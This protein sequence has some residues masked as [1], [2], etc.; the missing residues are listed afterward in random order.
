MF[1]LVLP[2]VFYTGIGIT[3]LLTFKLAKKGINSV[4]KY[5]IQCS[6]YSSSLWILLIF[7]FLNALV[8]DYTPGSVCA[9]QLFNDQYNAKL[10]FFKSFNNGSE[11]R[12]S[13][14][15]INDYSHNPYSVKNHN[16]HCGKI[17]EEKRLFECY[18]ELENVT[19]EALSNQTVMH[20]QYYLEFERYID[21]ITPG[22]SNYVENI[23]S[24]IWFQTND[25][26]TDLYLD[27]GR[28]TAAAL[29]QVI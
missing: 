20:E 18:E 5:L 10:A 3:N 22:A 16:T 8:I 25:C 2:I 13:Y 28:Q 9:G 4:I 11:I 23:F 7:K 19:K 26:D 27:L 6:S 14:K 29:F 17:K 15:L 1:R 21:A 12:N 24:S